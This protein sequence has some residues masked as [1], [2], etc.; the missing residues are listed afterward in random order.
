MEQNNIE[1][2]AINPGNIFDRLRLCWGHLDDWKN[3]KIV[4]KSKE[5]LDETAALFKPT[6]FTAYED[7][8]P[9]GMIEFLPQ[10]SL[11]K[12]G[13]CPCRV[14]PESKETPE[15]YSLGEEFEN[16]LFIS[17]LLVSKENQRKG[18]GRTLLTHLLESE[19]I[20]DFNG[21]LVYV[22][23][24]DET[25]DKHIHWPAGPKEFYLK[26][27]FVVEKTLDDPAGYLLCYGKRSV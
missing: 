15:R 20:K 12:L 4:Q 3:L 9:V 17:C 13:L 24:R 26:M 11:R 7:G 2:M 22:T 25:W 5:W 8:V 1:V 10:K 6:T 23:K 18:I 21:V 19:V 27:G 14:D 16:Y